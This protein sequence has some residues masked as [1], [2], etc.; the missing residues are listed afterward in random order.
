[1]NIICNEIVGSVGHNLTRFSSFLDAAH[2]SEKA[3]WTF[4]RLSA[5][6]DVLP[7]RP[8]SIFRF[9][10]KQWLHKIPRFIL[11]YQITN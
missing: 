2:A 6:R 8:E 9:I 1:M 11:F 4:P 7:G 10:K 5:A 3:T